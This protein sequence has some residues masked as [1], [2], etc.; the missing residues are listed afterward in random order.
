LR[1][2]VFGVA[3]SGDKIVYYDDVEEAFEVS[4]PDADGLLH[5]CGQFELCHALAQIRLGSR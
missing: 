1:E 5:G 4:A 2:D 3:Q